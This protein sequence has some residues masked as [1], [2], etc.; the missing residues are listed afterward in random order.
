MARRR[1]GGQSDRLEAGAGPLHHRRQSLQRLAGRRQRAGAGRGRRQGVDRRAG[2]QAHDRRRGRADRRRAR[3]R[4]PKARS[5]RRSCSPSAPPRSGDAYLRFI[6][7]TEMDIAVV[8][9]GVS[10]TLDE[11]RRRHSGPRGAG[12]RGA[13]GAAGGRGGA[14]PSSARSWT[15]AALEKLAKRLFGGLPPIDDKRGTIEFRNKVAGVL[16]RRAATIAYAARRRKVMSGV[17]C[18]NDDQWRCRRVPVPAGGDA[19]RR[20][21]RRLGLTG[22]KEGCGTGDCGACSVIARRPAGVLMPGARRGGRGPARRDHRGHGARRQAASAAA[23]VPRA[24]GAAMRHLH[25][26]LPDGGEGAAGQEPRSDR[27]RNPLRPGRQPLPL[28]RL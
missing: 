6:P 8:S 23:E 9:A 11:R 14:R 2:R 20:A 10:L 22:A 19:A 12:R 27:G 15:T 16:A 21:A 3:R 26:G 7:R 4:W 18:L 13:D 17:S 1:R 28:H 5:S 24:R 25:A